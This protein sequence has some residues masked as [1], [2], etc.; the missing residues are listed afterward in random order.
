MPLIV[1][2]DHRSNE[3][4]CNSG[5]QE[6][7][8][9]ILHPVIAAARRAKMM[10]AIVHFMIAVTVV[11][12]PLTWRPAMVPE[13]HAAAIIRRRWAIVPLVAHVIAIVLMVVPTRVAAR[14][15]PVHPMPISVAVVVIVAVIAVPIVVVLALIL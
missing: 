3:A 15:A 11:A 9:V 5:E 2:Q 1:A 8:V 14:I 4:R 6:V 13:G 12:E 7:A 10:A